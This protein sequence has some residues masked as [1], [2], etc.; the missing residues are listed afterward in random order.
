MGMGL[1]ASVGGNLSPD[2]KNLKIQIYGNHSRRDY[3]FSSGPGAEAGKI[4][5]D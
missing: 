1:E 5:A 4:F 2:A 3:R